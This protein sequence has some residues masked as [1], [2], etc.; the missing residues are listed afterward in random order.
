MGKRIIN[1]PNRRENELYF[2]MFYWNSEIQEHT[3]PNT[4]Y[5]IYSFSSFYSWLPDFSY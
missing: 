3:L 4:S 1:S 2:D 5:G